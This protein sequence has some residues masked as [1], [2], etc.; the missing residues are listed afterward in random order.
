MLG[1]QSLRRCHDAITRRLHHT[2]AKVSKLGQPSNASL[3]KT[4][5]SLERVSQVCKLYPLFYVNVKLLKFD[6]DSILMHIN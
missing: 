4:G 1:L 5:G 3:K 2:I 6:I